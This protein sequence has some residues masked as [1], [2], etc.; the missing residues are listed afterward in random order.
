MSEHETRYVLLIKSIN[1]FIKTVVHK[2]VILKHILDVVRC[3]F[4]GKS[5]ITCVWGGGRS[6]KSIASD[7]FDTSTEDTAEPTAELSFMRPK[8]LIS[9]LQH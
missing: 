4:L 7:Q 8:S 6:N 1:H 5:P 2:L 3:F 9:F